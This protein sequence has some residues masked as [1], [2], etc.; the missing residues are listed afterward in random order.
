M[1][2]IGISFAMAV[3]LFAGATIVDHG[4]AIAQSST[5]GSVRGRIV[6][7]KT[8]DAVIGATVSVSGPALQGQQSEI[9]DENGSFQ[10]SNLPPGT[11]ILTV[12][13]GEAQFNRPNVLIEVGKQAFVSVPIDTE[14]KASEVIELVGRTPLVDQ[15]STKIGSTITDEYTKNVPTGRTFGA[16][17]GTAAGTQGDQYGVS[18][19][20]A[21][22]VESSYVVEGINTTD[23]AFGGQSTN[24]PNEF[25]E[26]T[27]VIAGG[28]DAEFGR[29]TGGVINVVTKQGSNK[30]KGSIFAYYTPG[31]LISDAES[32]LS[33]ASAIGS[34]LNVDYVADMGFEVGG[35]I[36]K[37][38]LWFHVGYNPSFRR[39]VLDRIISTRVDRVDADGAGVGESFSTRGQP[40]NAVDSCEVDTNMNGVLDADEAIATD[41][42]PDNVLDEDGNSTG[43]FAQEEVPGTRVSRGRF[44]QTH[45]FTGKINGALSEN[46]RFQISGFGNPASFE[47]D[48]YQV[49]GSPESILFKDGDG[50]YDAALKWTSKFN[51]GKTQLDLVGGYHL[52][53]EDQDPLFEGGADRASLQDN[54]T[55]SL[56]VFK[57]Y[58]PG[59]DNACAD[60]ADG[61]MADPFPNIRNCPV[62]NYTWNGLG[63]LETRTNARTSGTVALTQRANLLGQHAFKVGA[64]LEY[65]TYNSDRRLTGGAIWQLRPSNAAGVQ[66]WRRRAQLAPDPA[67]VTTGDVPCFD[68]DGDGLGDKTC[69]VDPAGYQADTTNRNIGAYLQDSWSIRPNFTVNAGIR[70]EKQTG[71]VADDIVGTTSP[72]GEVVPETAFDIANMIAPRVGFV[73]DPTAEGRAKLMAHWGRFYE[74]VPMDLNVRAFGGE[75]TDFSTT[76]CT[77]L[78]NR[79]DV[80]QE[81]LEACD[82]YRAGN[83]QLGDGAE[84]VAPSLKGQYTDELILGGEYEVMA[85]F[86]MG[87][88]F[89]TRNMPRVIEDSSTDGGAHYLIVNPGEDFSADATDLRTEAAGLMTSNPELA[90]LLSARADV[91]DKIGTFD[92]P[93]RDYQ[94]VQITAQ[95]RFAKNAM[96]LASYTYSRSV[97]NYPGLFS[98]ETGQLDPNLTSLYD[99]PELMSNRYGAMGLDRPHNLK[100]DG[101]YQFD[102]KKAGIVTLGASL[103]GISGIPHNTLVGHSLYGADES[104]LL[105]RGTAGRS[106]FTTTADIKATYGRKINATQSIELFADI[107]NLFNTQDETDADERY[108]TSFADP[109]VGG[110]LSDLPHAKQNPLVGIT[111]RSPIKNTNFLNLNAR[112][113]PR[114]FRFGLRYSF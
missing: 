108:S 90:A 57:N 79:D 7:K 28:Y 40:G 3:G 113:A 38:K 45:F 4:D 78:N 5:T 96:L 99:L 100:V 65:T 93:I 80:T 33:Q 56:A 59:F 67:G 22:S 51:N 29:S 63:F 104:Y 64:D 70:W 69:T 55:R 72:E 15:G 52:G 16:V 47:R 13:Y 20:G 14:I 74:S 83:Y 48:F 66:R 37:D 46:H 109:I 77:T 68:L 41:C 11:Y 32:I 60:A 62:V 110:D 21:T 101:F 94:A 39:D 27:E 12:F 82:T 18:F 25:V 1:K 54:N 114:S 106:P 97:G 44:R 61:N 34:E 84:F 8:K 9:T 112:Q 42:L 26:E 81:E 76:G 36:I 24:L 49:T 17:L 103:R 107:F 85:D 6:D 10:I 31:T 23:T 102:L 58:E 53:Y 50:A 111:G 95:Q 30:F 75:I 98:T 73:W 71:Y 89:V 91:L 35:P 105:P 43:F 19:S 87:V 88:N 2:R 92:K 86:K